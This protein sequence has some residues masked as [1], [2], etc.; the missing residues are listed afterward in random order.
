[1]QNIKLTRVKLQVL[2]YHAGL[3]LC[4][5]T[6]IVYGQQK[7]FESKI[8][9]SGKVLPGL[10]KTQFDTIGS[11][12]VQHYRLDLTFPFISSEFSGSVT[13]ICLAMRA[14]EGVE[15][16]MGELTAD[17]IYLRGNSVSFSHQDD[18]LSLIFPQTISA[19]DTFSLCIQYHGA[20]DKQG[21]YFYDRCAYTFSEPE[22]A[23][24]WYPCHDVPWDKATAE[25]HITVPV[26]VDVASI[27]LLKKREISQDGFWV[28]FHWATQYPVATYLICVTMS[29]EYAV[30]SDWFVTADGDSI[31]MPYY[32]FIEDSDKAKI[33]VQ[34]M[35]AAM[36]YF[37]ETFGPY[38]FEKYGTATVEKAWF[39]GM[40][41]QTMTTVVKD[42]FRGNG[43]LESGF[44]HELAHMWWGDAV[45]LNNWPAIWLNEGFAT[46]SDMLFQDYFYSQQERLK[47]G[48]RSYRDTYL[49]KADLLDFPIYNPLPENLFNWEVTYLKGAWVLHMLRK[50][51]GDQAFFTILPHYYQQYKYKNTSISEFQAICESQYGQSLDWFFNEWIYG[52][53]YIKLGYQW[54]NFPVELGGYQV[55]LAIQEQNQ[56]YKMPLDVQLEYATRVMDTTL[57]LD[58]P[59]ELFVFNLS[60]S[61]RSITLDPDVWLLMADTLQNDLISSS[62]I[63]PESGQFIIAPNPFQ[64]E[65]YIQ[66]NL[67]Q[68]Q[69]EWQVGVNIY[70]ARGE[71]VRRIMNKK[72]DSG[73]YVVKWDGTDDHNQCLPSGV[74]IVEL[75]IEKTL[76]Y[77]KTMILR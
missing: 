34:N 23:R 65:T 35:Q 31:E 28:T 37:I 75:S 15:L 55:R 39:G 68:Q 72:Q 8:V 7:P 11:F 6:A 66:Y 70:N 4:L 14:L 3:I 32:V 24:Y 17:Q 20:P 33:D 38:P 46:Y 29:K 74:Y 1:M 48:M 63:L 54:K 60:D 57:W 16:H 64:K 51:V 36:A 13:L 25:L 27:G 2:F 44:V 69:S 49:K 61:V 50:V 5:C 21:F 40:E 12:D 77:S 26:G 22:D 19:E 62:D 59:M 42:W 10:F 52:S 56:M 58:S 41:H 71:R 18:I 47:N 53:G 45:T 67:S 76:Y 73:I 30:W 9:Q 43:S